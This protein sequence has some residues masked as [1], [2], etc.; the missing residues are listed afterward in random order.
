MYHVLGEVSGKEQVPRPQPERILDTSPGTHIIR[1]P[2]SLKQKHEDDS[3]IVFQDVDGTEQGRLMRGTKGLTLQTNSGDFAEWHP[4]ARACIWLSLYMQ[5]Q[6]HILWFGEAFAPNGV[7]HVNVLIHR[8]L[9]ICRTI[10][11]EVPFEEGDVVGISPQGLTR[12]TQNAPQIA[13][14]SRWAAIEAS[15]P[16]VADRDAFDRV[17]YTGQVP[18]K[19]RG[20]CNVGDIV[21]PSGC[22]DGF[23]KAIASDDSRAVAVPRLGRCLQAHDCPENKAEKNEFELQDLA[24][25]SNAITMVT[26]AVVSPADSIPAG[27]RHRRRLLPFSQAHAGVIGAVVLALLFYTAVRPLLMDDSHDIH[28]EAALASHVNVEASALESIRSVCQHCHGDHGLYCERDRLSAV[29]G[30][31][32]CQWS[33][34]GDSDCLVFAGAGPTAALRSCTATGGT[35]CV[36]S[37]W[38]CSACSSSAV[39]SSSFACELSGGA[40]ELWGKNQPHF[41]DGS[42]PLRW[43]D[44][45]RSRSARNVQCLTS[46]PESC[47]PPMMWNE[48]TQVR[49]RVCQRW[50]AAQKHDCYRCS[51][52]LCIRCVQTDSKIV[53]VPYSKRMWL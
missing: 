48:T 15:T 6:F 33:G 22:N 42:T 41:P 30:C 43:E 49:N 47:M 23:A 40:G 14:I 1:G 39:E 28:T 36:P 20:S 29:K 10:A 3:W 46:L 2:L 45:G 27:S 12:N 8:Y 5:R 17:A 24:C 19:L 9:S 26:I 38:S 4:R 50:R 35:V 18:V 32:R 37:P 13:V 11:G 21:V 7:M 52:K 25:G 31:S 34:N 44:K 51:Q 53:L 16:S